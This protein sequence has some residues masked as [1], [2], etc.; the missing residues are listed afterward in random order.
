MKIQWLGHAA[1]LIT[2]DGGVRIITDPYQLA[3][4]MTYGESDEAADFVTVSHEHG[5]HNNVAAVKGN[6]RAVRTTDDAGEIKFKG[7]PTYHDDTGGTQRGCNTV[8]A[9]GRGLLH[10][11]R[12]FVI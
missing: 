6:P 8:F 5:D 1:F 9:P 10:N 11:M 3:E 4:R 7:L 12:R 2:S